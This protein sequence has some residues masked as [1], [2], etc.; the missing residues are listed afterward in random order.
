MSHRTA[1]IDV[2]ERLAVAPEGHG[3]LLEAARVQFGGGALLATCNRLELYVPGG[4]DA[5]SDSAAALRFLG[6]R[7][8]ADAGTMESAFRVRHALD[9]ARHLLRVAS[10][11]DS[12]VVG[13]SEVLGQVRTAFAAS[14]TAG[15]EDPVLSH[16]FLTAIR[17]GRRARS[18]TA[19]GH[20][21][22]SVSSLAARAARRHL[23][24]LSRATA[25]VIGAGEAGRLAAETLASMGVGR[26]LIANRTPSRAEDLAEV[27]GGAAVSWQGLDGALAEADVV[28][29]AAGASQP[30]VTSEAARAAAN[31]RDGPAWLALDIALPRTFAPGI[32]N[33]PAVTYLDLDD[34]QAEAQRNTERRHGA[35]E[36]VEAIVEESAAE[37]AVWMQ[38]RAAVPTIRDLTSRAERLRHRQVERALRSSGL[39]VGERERLRG[40]ADALSKALVK[41]LLHEPI[42]SLRAGG[43]READAARRLFLLDEAFDR[44]D[45]P[46]SPDGD[47]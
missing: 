28:I 9:A 21:A 25:L 18:D 3:S 16:L 40:V 44:V 24:E 19:I 4:H 47:G 2:R 45:A 6:E 34:L 13:E 22:L 12:M 38:H 1:P 37:F 41:Q 11:L 15:A 8:G 33:L 5:A 20:G 39:D 10:G 26:L 36:A 7:I 27:L 14:V 42:R 29:G 30:V 31:R 35:I 17:T 23:G 43:Q 46:H 32:R